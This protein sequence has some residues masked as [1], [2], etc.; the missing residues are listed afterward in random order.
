MTGSTAQ[1]VQALLD[2]EA[3]SV[4][5]CPECGSFFDVPRVEPERGEVARKCLAC[6]SWNPVATLRWEGSE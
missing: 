3:P 1:R 4:F 5:R 6:E 2:R